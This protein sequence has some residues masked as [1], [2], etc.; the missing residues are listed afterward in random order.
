MNAE[1]NTGLS[2][3]TQKSSEED[4]NNS[5]YLVSREPIKGSPF[6]KTNSDG[7]WFISWGM[8]RLSDEL[9]EEED[10]PVYM[11]EQKWNL[12]CAYMIAIQQEARQYDKGVGITQEAEGAKN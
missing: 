8:W 2:F 10:I 3:S 5:T 7:K 11:E 4:Q 9:E 1:N 12:I 6:E